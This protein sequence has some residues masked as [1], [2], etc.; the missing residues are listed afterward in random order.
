MKLGGDAEILRRV[1]GEPDARVPEAA[2][3]ALAG[4]LGERALLV[5]AALGQ[6]RERL[7]AERVDAGVDPVVEQRR[8]AEAGDPCRPPR[9]RRRRTASAPARRRSSPRR[10][11]RSCSARS[12]RKSTSSSSSPFSASTVPSSRRRDAARRRPPPRPSGSGSPTA[13]IS[14]PRPASAFTNA[15]SCPARHAT[16]TRVTPAPT[17][18][19]TRVLGERKARDRHERLRQALRRLAEPLRLAA[20]EEQRL[21]Q[22]C[23]SGRARPRAPPATRAAGGRCP[24]RRS[25]PRASRPGRAGCGRRRSAAAPSRRASPAWRSPRAR[26]TR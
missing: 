9:G 11:T 2:E 10:P 26:A 14:A 25:R 7:L 24:R 4:E 6:P 3:L 23:S 8:L 16:I 21:H 17:S 13:S 20:R 22:S 5:V 18:R 1:H 12:A 15:S 19:A